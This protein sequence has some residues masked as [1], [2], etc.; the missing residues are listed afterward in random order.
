M[1][2]KPYR[3][4]FR[5]PS[6]MYLGLDFFAENRPLAL[7]HASQLATDSTITKAHGPLAVARVTRHEHD[8][9]EAGV[10]YPA[11]WIGEL[12]NFYRGEKA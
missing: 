8:G 2:D 7:S 6:G 11:I 1:A 9:G 12:R 10:F 5:T 3:V 4:I